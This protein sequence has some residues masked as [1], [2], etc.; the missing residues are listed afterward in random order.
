MYQIGKGS[1]ARQLLTGLE[2]LERSVVNSGGSRRV[3][4]IRGK[5]VVHVLGASHG[6]ASLE[7][8]HRGGRGFVTT[9]RQSKSSIRAKLGEKRRVAFVEGLVAGSVRMRRG[10]ADVSRRLGMVIVAENVAALPRPRGH[11]PGRAK[12]TRP[13]K[14]PRASRR[15]V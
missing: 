15:P 2:T 5:M 8:G 9:A 1:L 11:N 12:T 10:L 3:A 13:V 6:V 14:A 7:G 4:A